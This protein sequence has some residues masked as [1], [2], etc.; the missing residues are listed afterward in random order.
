[1]PFKMFC[2]TELSMLSEI[3]SENSQEEVEKDPDAGCFFSISLLLF[4]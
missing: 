2:F 1:M 4:S 3:S